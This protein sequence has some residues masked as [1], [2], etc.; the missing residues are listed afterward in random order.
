[1][2]ESGRRR[3]QWRNHPSSSSSSTGHT[4]FRSQ[5]YSSN[6]TKTTRSS[7]FVPRSTTTTGT[8]PHNTRNPGY[9]PKWK[10]VSNANNQQEG[11]TEAGE[12]VGS[13]VGTCPFMCP[14]GERA[15]RERLRDLAIFER[16]NGDPRKTSAALAVKKF[17]RTISLK[18]VQASDVRPLSV[19]EDTLNYLLNLLDWS[20][21]PFE[22]VH[23]FIFDRTRSIRQDLGMQNI[24]NDRA[25]CMYEKRFYRMG[26]YRSFLCTVSAEASYLQYCIIEPYVNEVRALAV[27]YINNCCYKLHPY[28]LEH[29]SKLL[30]M[31]ESDME[32]FCHACGLKTLSDDGGNKLLP[33]KQTTFC[34]PKGSFQSCSILGLEQYQRQTAA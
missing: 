7:N 16:L 28:P 8:T 5:Q 11:E 15:Q 31:K 19:L 2:D 9:V 20:E 4:R 30:M 6:P 32:S 33:T 24:V 22:V 26:N 23:D 10:S 25:I 12:E 3:Q 1:M 14:E 21:H 13:I 34:N 29:L 18:Y 17:C 27:S